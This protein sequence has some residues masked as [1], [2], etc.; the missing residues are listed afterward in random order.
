MCSLLLHSVLYYLSQYF[1]ILTVS[2]WLLATPSMLLP[3]V[4]LISAASTISPSLPRLVKKKKYFFWFGN[5]WE[6][7]GST[8][9]FELFSTV[10]L[11]D[12]CPAATALSP[13][14]HLAHVQEE[15]DSRSLL[16]HHPITINHNYSS[17]SQTY[18]TLLKRSAL[19][20]MVKEMSTRITGWKKQ[21]VQ[22]TTMVGE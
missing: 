8:W 6:L 11:I 2:D 7:L 9:C 20:E 19:K 12:V 16:V 21:N 13:D 3:P 10:P 18:T 14:T 15:R 5:Q 1:T 22:S 17:G 4:H